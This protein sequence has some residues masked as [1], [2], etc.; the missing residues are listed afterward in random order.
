[1]CVCVCVCMHLSPHLIVGAY[2]TELHDEL[3]AQEVVGANGLQLQQPTQGHQ[4]GPHQVVQRQLVLKQ[5]GEADD[6]LIT[7]PL[8]RVTDLRYRAREKER[9]KEKK[10]DRE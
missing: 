1:M 10:R 9:E 4:L 8:T 6:L 7:G 5:L 3:K 2:G